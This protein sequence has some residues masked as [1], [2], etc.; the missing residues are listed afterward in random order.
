MKD[1]KRD[2]AEDDGGE[3]NPLRWIRP[4]KRQ[5]IDLGDKV[6]TLCMART[7]AFPVRPHMIAVNPAQTHVIVS[8]VATGHVLFIEANSRLTLSCAPHPPRTQN[9][10]EREHPSWRPPLAGVVVQDAMYMKSRA[11]ERVAHNNCILFPLIGAR[12]T[13]AHANRPAQPMSVSSGRR[14]TIGYGS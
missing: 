1:H 9:H 4:P 10:T 13:R 6:A 14:E 3:F 8:F 2:Q 5:R 7:G 11:T 12:R